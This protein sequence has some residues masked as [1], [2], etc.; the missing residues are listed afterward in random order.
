MG[1][2]KWIPRFP[3]HAIQ[4]REHGRSGNDSE[5]H[6]WSGTHHPHHLWDKIQTAQQWKTI[7]FISWCLSLWS[8]LFLSSLALALLNDCLLQLHNCTLCIVSCLH[9]FAYAVPQGWK[10]FYHPVP[11][12]VALTNFYLFLWHQ[13]KDSLFCFLDPLFS[14]NCSLYSPLYLVNP[15]FIY[16]PAS[17]AIL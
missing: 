1:S 6:R 10:S 13:C 9:A 2:R 11:P 15:V 8:S 12:L 4:E 3:T 16:V 5:D 14:H 7:A 17:C